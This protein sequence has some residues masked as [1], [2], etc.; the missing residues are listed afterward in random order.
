MFFFCSSGARALGKS[1]IRRRLGN[2]LLGAGV[3]DRK[4]RK[5]RSCKREPRKGNRHR[6]TECDNKNN[7]N[8]TVSVHTRTKKEGTTLLPPDLPPSHTSPS[9]DPAAASFSESPTATTTQEGT[10]SEGK[11]D[12]VVITSP[13]SPSRPHWHQPG[14]S[15][16]HSSPSPPSAGKKGKGKKNKQ[17][18]PRPSAPI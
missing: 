17:P 11:C 14:P 18:P 16:N 6:V 10:Q 4:A 12:P 13:L 2:T 7:K 8:K 3:L 9:H 5:R 15:R 1:R